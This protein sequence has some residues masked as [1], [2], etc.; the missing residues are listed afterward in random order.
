MDHST[1]KTQ[2]LNFWGKLKTVKN[3]TLH[4]RSRSKDETGWN[5]K[6]KGSVLVSM[7]SPTVIT[8]HERGSWQGE[9]NAGIAFSNTFR[10]TLEQNTGMVSLEHL[11]FG[12]HHPVFLLHLSPIENHRLASVD[13]HLCKED[14]YLAQVAWDQHG[15]RF[16]WR[17][18]GPKK[19]EEIGC[20][21][22]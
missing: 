8:F 2:L 18:I 21:Y 19:N 4:A 13:S 3:L 9:Q 11:R 12:P 17:V 20:F 15:I 5:G 14:E 1:K 6:G 10:W 7:D 22:F 16:S